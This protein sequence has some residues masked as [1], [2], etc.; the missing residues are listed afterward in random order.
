MNGINILSTGE[1]GIGVT[2][3]AR[4]NTVLQ[5]KDGIGFPDT[6]VASTDAHTLDSYE[7]GTWTP[8]VASMTEVGAATYS[9]YY[10]VI[11]DVMFFTV[12]IAPDTST[13]STS[14]STTLTLPAGF[15]VESISTTTWVSTGNNSMGTGFIHTATDKIYPPAWSANV[16]DIYGSGTCKID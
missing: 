4:N 9:G 11:G 14:N 1:V 7:E 12:L 10:T 6:A 2:P 3:T 15:S 16:N 13:A 5:I 8:T